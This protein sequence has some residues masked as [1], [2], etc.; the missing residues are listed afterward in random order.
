VEDEYLKNV[1]WLGY[2]VCSLKE[3]WLEMKEMLRTCNVFSPVPEN[4]RGYTI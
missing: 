3:E 4:A 2:E 1:F